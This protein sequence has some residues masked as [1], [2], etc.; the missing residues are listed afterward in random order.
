MTKYCMICHKKLNGSEEA[1]Y[2]NMCRKCWLVTCQ[3]HMP[4]FDMTGAEWENFCESE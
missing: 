3:E 4:G 2:G 1:E